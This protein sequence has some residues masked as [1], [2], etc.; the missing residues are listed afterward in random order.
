M[1][2]EEEYHLEKKRRLYYQDIVYRVCLVLDR[3]VGKRVACGTAESPTT[4]V[5]VAINK[6]W[7]SYKRHKQSIPEK[8]VGET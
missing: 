6:L 5:E 3:F 2:W 4:E 7:E 1:D 8:M